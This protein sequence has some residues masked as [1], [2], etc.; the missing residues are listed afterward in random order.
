MLG[1][2]CGFKSEEKIAKRLSPLVRC[3]GAREVL[4]KKRASELVAEGATALL[5]FGVAGGLADNLTPSDI[6]IGSYVMDSEGRRYDCEGAMQQRFAGAAPHAKHGGVFGSTYVIDTAQ[7]KTQ[8]RDKTGALIVDME[9]HVIAEIAAEHGLPFGVLRGI[10]DAAEAKL[11]PAVLCGI[12][13]DG[14]ENIAGVLKSLAADPTQLPAL[15]HFAGN[16]GT[17]LKAL[18]RVIAAL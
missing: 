18:A 3:S 9:S 16:T 10:S 15:L 8:W 6:I 5:S 2:L 12:N 7:A 13:E 4:A 17:A 11:P 1:I 14:S